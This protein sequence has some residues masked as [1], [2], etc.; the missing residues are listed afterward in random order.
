MGYLLYMCVRTTD[1][2]DVPYPYSFAYWNMLD[3][4][5]A[6]PLRPEEPVY[7]ARGLNKFLKI[8]QEEEDN[9]A[10]ATASTSAEEV[11]DKIRDPE[12]E[13]L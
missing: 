4:G 8:R 7:M 6:S 10:A 3:E 2:D 9:T 11:Q 1:A 5:R 13:D 12:G